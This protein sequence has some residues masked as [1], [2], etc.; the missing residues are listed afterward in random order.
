[1]K[2]EGDGYG[3]RA[4]QSPIGPVGQKMGRKASEPQ[5]TAK[6]G[7]NGE[8]RVGAREKRHEGR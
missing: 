1:M 2:L 8:L 3:C 7:D 4:G 5:S 6:R